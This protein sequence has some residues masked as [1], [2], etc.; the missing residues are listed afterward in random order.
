M[1]IEGLSSGKLFE[2]GPGGSFLGSITDPADPGSPTGVVLFGLGMSEVRIA[3]G[4]ARLG[5]VAM[6]IRLVKNYHDSDRRNRF[7]DDS[8]VRSCRLAIDEL[9]ARRGV[10]QVI[11]MGNCAEANLCFNTALL[12]ARVVGLILTNPHVNEVLTA[13]HSYPRKLFR[14]SAWR[15]LL[16][17]QSNLD[18]LRAFVRGRLQGADDRLL[19]AQSPYRHDIALPLDFDRKLASLVKRGVRALIVFS[20]T[21]DGLHYFRNNYGGTL[22]ELVAANGLTIQTLERDAHVFSRDDESAQQLSEIVFRW[23]EKALVACDWQRAP[24]AASAS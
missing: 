19:A 10:R 2:F 20:H 1:K 3:R 18:A 7:Y 8:G 14:L 4:L 22:A 17:G 23:G 24:A 11:L 16:T 9:F 13:A 5:L 6:Q 12:D 21:E 15:R